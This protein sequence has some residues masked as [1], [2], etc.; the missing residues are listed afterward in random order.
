[1]ECI[2]HIPIRCVSIP[3]EEKVA[4]I[5]AFINFKH[6]SIVRGY[7]FAIPRMQSVPNNLRI[8]APFCDSVINNNENEFEYEL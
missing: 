3:R 2:G 4:K 1:M 8:P 6:I 5:K 7:L